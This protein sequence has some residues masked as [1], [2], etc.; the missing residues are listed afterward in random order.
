MRAR[1][2]FPARLLLLLSTLAGSAC[3][4][5]Y[6][7]HFAYDFAQVTPNGNR[8]AAD[9][10]GKLE[11]EDS[12]FTF[13]W[14]PAATENGLGGLCSDVANRLDRPAKILWGEAEFVNPDGVAGPVVVA[15][16]TMKPFV[17]TVAAAVTVQAGGRAH[18]LVVPARS[19]KPGQRLKAVRYNDVCSWAHF[20]RIKPLI[21]Y[22]ERSWP[23]SPAK[24]HPQAK[25]WLGRRFSVT[26]PVLVDG[27]VRRYHFDLV[28]RDYSV[29]H[30]TDL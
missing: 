12:A 23:W 3:T 24:L 1:S 21:P 26:V 17:D 7:V 20:T 19:F 2:L 16:S 28:V 14:S 13:R 5:V 30:Y 11:Y 4:N 22:L 8:Q 10:L 27:V 18:A 29:I 9:S 25:R 6:Y 15:D